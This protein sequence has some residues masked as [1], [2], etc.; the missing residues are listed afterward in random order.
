MSTDAAAPAWN[1]QKAGRRPALSANQPNT[2][3]PI[4]MPMTVIAVHMPVEVRDSPNS[5][6]RYFG[7]QV[8]MPK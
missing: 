8:M 5:E 3:I 6:F 2:E 1:I 7:S 4:I